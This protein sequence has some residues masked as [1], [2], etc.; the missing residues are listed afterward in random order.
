MGG[1]E[2][3]GTHGGREGGQG[4]AAV[5]TSSATSSPSLIPLGS[6]AVMS[7]DVEKIEDERLYLCCVTQSRDQQT[8]YAKSSGKQVPRPQS[9]SCLLCPQSKQ[10][11]GGGAK[12]LVRVSGLGTSCRHGGGRQSR[13]RIFFP[14]TCELPVLHHRTGARSWITGCKCP[15]RPPSARLVPAPRLALLLQV[16]S[17][18]CLWKRSRPPDSHHAFRRACRCP[19][20]LP[21]PATDQEGDQGGEGGDTFL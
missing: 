7:I 20:C 13:T 19:P 21:E 2:G 1:K 18:G 8:V 3:W 5:G 10:G 4:T 12:D 11:A 16:F 9:L 17:F 15:E 6:L 14:P